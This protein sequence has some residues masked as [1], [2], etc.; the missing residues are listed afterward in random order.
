M[1]K[2][3]AL[4]VFAFTASANAQ[5]DI[6]TPHNSLPEAINR[7]GDVSN[8]A[9]NFDDLAQ[10]ANLCFRIGAAE[11][12]AHGLSNAIDQAPG[13]SC[14]RDTQS[15]VNEIRVLSIRT[16]TYCGADMS[17][18]VHVEVGALVRGQPRMNSKQVNA[19]LSRMADLGQQVFTE[20]QG[21]YRN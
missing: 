14:I 6:H 10:A 17:N 3:L 8:A 15:K 1:K 2:T 12:S 16:S 9:S 19:A 20:L 4:L 7:A 5:I 13:L 18:G 21:C 11:R